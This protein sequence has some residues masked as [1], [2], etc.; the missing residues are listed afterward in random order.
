MKNVLIAFEPEPGMFI[1]TMPAFAELL[2]RLSDR[3]ET[4]DGVPLL[5][6]S[7]AGYSRPPG[8]C[9]FQAVA[10]GSEQCELPKI[11]TSKPAFDARHRPSAMPGRTADPRRHPPLVIAP[12][13]RAYRGH[14]PRRPRALD[15]RRKARSTSR[16]SCGRWPK[17]VTLAAF[18]SSSAA[19]ATKARWAAMQAFKWMENLVKKVAEERGTLISTDSR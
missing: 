4:Q 9:L 2:T 18:T 5:A 3:P 6:T 17:S 12:G 19:T 1:D 14:A 7:S 8:H 16:P 15:V 10:H 13:K 11:E